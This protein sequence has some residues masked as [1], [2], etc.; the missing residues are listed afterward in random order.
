VAVADVT[1]FLL[2]TNPSAGS[3]EDRELLDLARSRLGEVEIVRMGADRDLGAAVR[4]AVAEDRVVVAAGGDGTVSAVIQHL[5]PSGTLGVLPAGTW[6][7]FARD[8][9]IE[10]LETGLTVL[11]SGRA[12]RIDVGR[13]ADRLFAN[14]VGMGLYPELV[15]ERTQSKGRWGWLLSSIGAAIR[16]LRRARPVTGSIEVDG[17]REAFAA[18]IIMVGNNRFTLRPGRVGTRDRLDE[19]VLELWLMTVGRG[20]ARRMRPVWRVLRGRLW[21]SRRIVRTP[22]RFVRIDVSGLPQ[23]VSRD[24]EASER[25]SSLPVEILPGALRVLAP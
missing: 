22:A 21:Q 20:I 8:L 3:E 12:R 2:V 10:D 14:N 25:T 11:L 1:S 18:W 5:V 19:G 15:R 9:G 23:L 16:V 24:G 17:R 7:H 6:N 13:A 4:A